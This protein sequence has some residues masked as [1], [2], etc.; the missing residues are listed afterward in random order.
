MEL[1]KLAKEIAA[2]ADECCYRG[3]EWEERIRASALQKLT[4]TYNAALE[5]AAKEA[6]LWDET[7]PTRIR[8]L[9]K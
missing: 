9:K 2:E 8:N 5:E 6:E 7:V 4:N 1:E 3:G